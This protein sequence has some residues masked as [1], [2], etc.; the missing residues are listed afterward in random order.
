M[1]TGLSVDQT[2][3]NYFDIH[4]PAKLQRLPESPHDCPRIQI[5]SLGDI[6]YI[7]LYI[8]YY[9]ILYYIICIIILQFKI[10]R[11]AAL[12]WNYFK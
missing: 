9:I 11:V 4:S 3:A 10:Y 12:T 6:L 7:L 8:I 2:I 1:L 5:G